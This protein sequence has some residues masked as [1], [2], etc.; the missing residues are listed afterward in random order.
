MLAILASCASLTGS[1]HA[2]NRVAIEPVGSRTTSST[3]SP[4][5]AADKVGRYR[6][7]ESDSLSV[8]FPLTPE[9]NQT[10]N[11][12]PDGFVT[13]TG[14]GILYIEGMTTDQAADAIRAAYVHV[15]HNPV[16]TVE[17]K[18]FNKPY[19]LV[20]GQVAKPG[21]YD[22]RGSTSAA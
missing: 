14:A 15:L 7:Q 10:V 20:T 2:D 17:L 22:L 11:V 3:I 12:Q 18:D 16:V 8:T 13:L 1:A 19:F 4:A 6:I 21:K 9:F 5:A